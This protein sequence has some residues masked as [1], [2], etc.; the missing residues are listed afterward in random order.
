MGMTK[1]GVAA[2]FETRGN[3]DGHVILRG[4]KAPNYDAAGMS[5][6]PAPCCAR[7][8]CASR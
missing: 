2:I 1:M 8:A 3:A 6:P 7:P 4:G 5:R